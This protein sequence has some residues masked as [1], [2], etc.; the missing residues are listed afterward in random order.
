MDPRRNKRHGNSVLIIA[1]NPGSEPRTPLMLGLRIAG[2]TQ[3]A[4]RATHRGTEAPRRGA[5][6]FGWAQAG[7]RATPPLTLRPDR[8]TPE[9][10]VE[11]LM[12]S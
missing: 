9:G 2:A 8:T 10:A 3:G 12:A 1:A 11:G 7:P 6:S 4:R 5:Q